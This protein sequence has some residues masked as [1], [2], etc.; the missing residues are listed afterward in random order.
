[1]L[2]RPMQSRRRGYSAV[3][4]WALL[5]AIAASIPVLAEC[6]PNREA[7][8]ANQFVRHL[9][10]DCSHEERQALAVPAADVIAAVKEGKSLD[11][12]GVIVTGDLLLDQLPAEPA[13]SVHVTS[14]RLNDV[15]GERGLTT[16]RIIRGALSIRDSVITGTLATRLQDGLL[17]IDGPVDLSGTQFARMLDLSFT[18]FGGAVDLSGAVL[19]K[20]G[21]FVR[22]VFTRGA[23]FDL[24][25]FGGHARFH[26]ARFAGPASFVRT[27]FNGL[28]EFLEVTFEQ[29]ASFSRAYFK[30][31]TG[32]SGSRFAGV[33]DFSEALF[34]HEAYFSYAE[35]ERDAYFR[36]TTFRGRADFGEARF[37]G[38]DDFS[39]VMFEQTPNFAGAKIPSVPRQPGGLQNAKFLYVIAALLACFTVILII[40]M[41]RG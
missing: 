9:G 29:E 21:F 6:Q 13:S 36:R 3:G 27:G 40:F 41:R 16:V 11:L 37:D 34:E 2:L 4:A 25:A 30:M 24:T 18:G 12:R 20:E 39:K 14:S 10:P 17:I 32:F 33:L 19:L 23:K 7:G 38:L 5:F 22:S 1:M 26:R 35:F 15:I 28:T 31:G 8:A